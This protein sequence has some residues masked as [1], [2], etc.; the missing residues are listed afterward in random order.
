MN[1]ELYDD[2]LEIATKSIK[3]VNPSKAIKTT[4]KDFKYPKGNT[5]M[6]AI[7][8]AAYT[9]AKETIKNINIKKGIVITKYGH[10]KGKL[11][12]VKIF[13]AGHP[14]LDSN[15][16][17]ATEQAIKLAENLT[18]DDKVI[19]LISG[20]GSA[21]FESPLI[22][23]KELQ[24]INDQL[25]KSGANIKEINTVRKKL[26]KVKGGKFA[27][28]CS[29]ASIYNVILS[30]VINNPLDMIAS[31]PTIADSS[32]AEEAT[33]IIKKYN[34]NISNKT[35]KLLKYKPIRKLNNVETQILLDNESL[36][37][38]ANKICENLGY[39]TIYISNPVT[40]S[41]TKAKNQLSKYFKDLKPKTVIIAGGEVV[42][43]VKGNGIGGRNQE[44]ALTLGK[45]IN[46]NKTAVMCIGS[47]GT[48]GPTDVA[49]AYVDKSII[50]KDL[51]DYLNDNDSY[52]YLKK[53]G[54]HIKTGPTGTNVCDLYLIIR[55]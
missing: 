10:S 12:N 37:L 18:K 30:D 46:D 35:S 5:Y 50:K 17:K 24:D 54:G 42:V 14:I 2:C 29:P 31:G 4:L 48:D 52:N 28:I 6:I 19:F 38:A 15:S 26:S 45:Y 55:K 21:L 53:Y 47:D 49:G 11:K 25:L 20:G 33:K 43:K 23:L 7:G 8:K 16:I 32:T 39:K 9:M 27:K 1:K 51:D 22:P 41:I 36:K 40:S 44:L 34:I 13:E 3:N